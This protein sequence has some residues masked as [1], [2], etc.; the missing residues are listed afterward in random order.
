MTGAPPA[1]AINKDLGLFRASRNLPTTREEAIRENVAITARN[2]LRNSQR[3]DH[4]HIEVVESDE[5]MLDLDE[6]TPNGALRFPDAP[7]LPHR[8]VTPNNSLSNVDVLI[9]SLTPGSKR[10]VLR[11]LENE[12][13]D[14]TVPDRSSPIEEFP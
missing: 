6:R 4:T 11:R 12:C 7:I 2:L 3:N 13:G 1:S 9:S 14:K 10:K 8:P 5:D